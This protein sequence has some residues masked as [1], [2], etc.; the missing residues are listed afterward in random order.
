MSLPIASTPSC[1]VDLVPSL[2]RFKQTKR[3]IRLL[4]VP[5][6]KNP[7]KTTI[8]EIL[9][10][11]RLRLTLDMLGRRLYVLYIDENWTSMNWYKDL[12][13]CL[14][15]IQESHKVQSPQI[16]GIKIIQC[17]F[18]SH[19]P[20]P[21]TCLAQRDRSSRLIS[22]HGQS[23]RKLEAQYIPLHCTS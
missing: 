10:C 21:P 1:K 15:E 18:V 12:R 22:F 6:G 2:S 19:S 17:A 11:Y 16:S 8:F 7:H 20:C 9:S 23:L 14:A 5:D 13:R 4:T 3:S